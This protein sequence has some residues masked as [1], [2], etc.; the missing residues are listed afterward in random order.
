MTLGVVSVPE[1]TAAA[2]ATAPPAFKLGATPALTAAAVVTAPVAFKLAAALALTAAAVVT[3]PV[4]F[5]LAAALVLTAADVVTARVAF[6]LAAALALTPAGSADRCAFGA[7]ATAVLTAV[8]SV[9]TAGQKSHARQ[10]QRLQCISAKF[11]LQNEAHWAVGTSWVNSERQDES[12]A[13]FEFPGRMG[14]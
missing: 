6:K 8:R 12:S 2:V 1:A 13:I 5:K 11:C 3:A 14:Q 10:R 7:P 4:A 9:S